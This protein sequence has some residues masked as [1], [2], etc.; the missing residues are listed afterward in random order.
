MHKLTDHFPQKSQSLKPR[1]R[2]SQSEWQALLKTQKESQLSVAEFCRQ[3]GLDAKYFSKRKRA[4]E[5]QGTTSAPSRF[6]KMPPPSSS[7]PMSNQELAL[8]HQN[9][10]LVLHTGIDARWVADLMKALS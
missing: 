4:F 9:T 7:S 6:I 2:R 5:T 1:K 8:H 10:R 3:A